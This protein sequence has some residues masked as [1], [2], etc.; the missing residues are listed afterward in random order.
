MR[1]QSDGGPFA[2]NFP[3][4]GPSGTET[5][6]HTDRATTGVRD[7]ETSSRTDKPTS[8]ITAGGDFRFV[9]AAPHFGVSAEGTP[10]LFN[11]E[12]S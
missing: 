9:N 5:E 8:S 1:A 11:F 6:S 12:F 10:F 7:S 2:F 3:A 4:N